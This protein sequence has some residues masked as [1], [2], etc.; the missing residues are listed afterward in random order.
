[1][2]VAPSAY[3]GHIQ[4]F[5][6]VNE[7]CQASLAGNHAAAPMN[8]DHFVGVEKPAAAGARC[9]YYLRQDCVGLSSSQRRWEGW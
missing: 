3:R 4:P 8:G 1:M 5:D 7:F 9:D 2:M 6:I